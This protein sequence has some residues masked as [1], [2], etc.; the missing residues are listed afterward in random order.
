VTLIPPEI[1]SIQRSGDD[2][3]RLQL[4]LPPALIYFQGHFPSSPILP[5]VV[6]LG[7]AIQYARELFPLQGEFNA[8]EALKF[9]QVLQPGDRPSLELEFKAP[10]NSVFFRYLSERGRHSSGSLIFR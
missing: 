1:E 5:G 3:A 4:L 8:M 7:W 10:K 9:Q 6:Q 2:K